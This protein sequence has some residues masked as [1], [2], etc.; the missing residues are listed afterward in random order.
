MPLKFLISGWTSVAFSLDFSVDVAIVPGP[1]HAF[2]W[3]EVAAHRSWAICGTV[4]PESKADLIVNLIFK[5]QK[6]NF[7]RFRIVQIYQMKTG[8]F[9]PNNRFI[10]QKLNFGDVKFKGFQ[11][12]GIAAI[13]PE[14]RIGR[15]NRNIS[16]NRQKWNQNRLFLLSPNKSD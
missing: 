9:P 1:V 15:R 12:K 14:N 13:Q 11:L 10:I 2:C 6:W 8:R 16:K 7:H 5:A 4:N 3:I